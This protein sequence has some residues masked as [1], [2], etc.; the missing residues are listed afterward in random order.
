M[1]AERLCTCSE[2]TDNETAQ[3]LTLTTVKISPV[4]LI[5]FVGP[6]VKSIRG[7]P[8]SV[9]L[10][11]FRLRWRYNPQ[12]PFLL[13]SSRIF[14]IFSTLAIKMPNRVVLAF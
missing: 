13:D 10:A 11:H 3:I 8:K 6:L 2:S 12:S 7:C 9:A 4:I 5:D 14:I 1:C